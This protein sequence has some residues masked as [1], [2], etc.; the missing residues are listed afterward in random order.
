LTGTVFKIIS[1]ALITVILGL[2]LR[3]QGKDI[4]LLM[5]IAACCMIVIAGI[6]YIKQVIEFLENLQK[7]IGAQESAFRTLLKAIGI[8]LVSEIACLICT[9]AGNAALGKTI[10]IVTTSVLLWLSLPM[11]NALLELVQ[12]ILGGL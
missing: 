3:Q 7:I 8:S 5:S 12:Q 2:F 6:A 1:G 10:Q 11:M 4:A 9:D